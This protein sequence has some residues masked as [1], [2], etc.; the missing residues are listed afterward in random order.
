MLL[1]HRITPFVLSLF[2]F[3]G[4]FFISFH[5]MSALWFL[6][7]I[8]A[9]CIFLFGR[10]ANINLQEKESWW[11]VVIPFL[12]IFSSLLLFLLTDDAFIR[13][14]VIFAS[15]FMIYFYAEH[16]FRFVH[17]PSTYQ[18]YSLQNSAGIMAVMSIFFLAS[19]GYALFFFARIPLSLFIVIFGV[20]VV[21][22]SYA[23]LWISKVQKDRIPVYALAAGVLCSELLAAVSYLPIVAIT[24]GAMIAVLFYMYLGLCRAAL[25][26]KLSKMVVRRYL[27]IGTL[28]LLAIILTAEWI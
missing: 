15:A 24:S 13:V 21:I 25:L 28:M 14:L 3:L 26:A 23:A 16:L 8:M 6:P 7:V 19:G 18:A 17:L 4:L 1:L 11:L 9:V 2:L 27:V 5:P 12:Y 10:L 20:L 22:L